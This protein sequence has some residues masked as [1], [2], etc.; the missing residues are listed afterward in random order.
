MPRRCGWRFEG[1]LT[2]GSF[3][4]DPQNKASRWKDNE[5]TRNYLNLHDIV[6]YMFMHNPK[7]HGTRNMHLQKMRCFLDPFGKFYVW[8]VLGR[9]L[10]K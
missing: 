8:L 7:K 1:L 2:V 6:G 10:P 5:L 3:K 4:G 9:Y